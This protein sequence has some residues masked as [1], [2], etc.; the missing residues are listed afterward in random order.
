MRGAD[1]FKSYFDRSIWH[2]LCPPYLD[3][4]LIIVGIKTTVFNGNQVSCMF[5]ALLGIHNDAED[6]VGTGD[7]FNATP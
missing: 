3:H 4:S 1:Y 2:K 6:L 5:A 7:H